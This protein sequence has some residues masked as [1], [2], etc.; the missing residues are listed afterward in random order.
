MID[1][2]LIG[3]IVSR[4][5]VEVERGRLRFFNQVTG[6]TG[7]DG[8]HGD[9]LLVPPTFLFCLEMERP[10]PYDWY[11]GAGLDLPRILH[12]EQSFDYLAPCYAGDVL[13]FEAR[14]DDIY[15]KKAGT[16]KFLVKSTRVSNQHGDAIATLRALLI[17][18]HE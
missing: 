5:A 8:I 14:I 6:E 16:L 11:A 17:Q 10:D 18:R 2:T 4:H 15:D 9:R 7:K 12:G 13:H 1:R 3:R